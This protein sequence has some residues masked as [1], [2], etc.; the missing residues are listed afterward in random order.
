MVEASK[1]HRLHSTSISYI[2]NVF[3]HLDMLWLDMWVHPY[4]DTMP[5]KM[6]VDFW[7][8]GGMAESE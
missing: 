1:P 8:I 4:T 7:D 5:L 2:Y 3:Q 6:G